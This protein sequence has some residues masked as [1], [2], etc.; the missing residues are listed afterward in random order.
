MP[1][2][3]SICL[4]FLIVFFV[5]CMQQNAVFCILQHVIMRENVGTY[6]GTY[7][8]FKQGTFLNEIGIL[9]VVITQTK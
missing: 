4:E 6:V 7:L 9:F 5:D 3:I 1:L 2:V 8:K